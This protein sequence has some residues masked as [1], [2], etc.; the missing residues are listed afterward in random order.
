MRSIPHTEQRSV[1]ITSHTC[2]RPIITL[3][4]KKG[5]GGKDRELSDGEPEVEK[6]KKMCG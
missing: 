1:W 3:T 4:G 6:K 5:G 2:F